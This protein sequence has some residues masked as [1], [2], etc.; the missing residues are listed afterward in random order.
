MA[1]HEFCN[2]VIQVKDSWYLTPR[3]QN[4]SLVIRYD[5]FQKIFVADAIVTFGKICF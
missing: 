1:R 4:G 5:G 2:F 3:M